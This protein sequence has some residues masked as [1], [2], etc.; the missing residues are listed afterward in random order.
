M[1]DQIQI[2]RDLTKWPLL[3]VVGEP[4]SEE[5]ANE[6]LVRTNNWSLST[7]D[8]SF[9]QQVYDLIGVS[10][11]GRY[12]WPEAESLHQFEESVQA[13]DLHYLSNHQVVSAWIGGPHGWCDWSGRIGS[14]N[15]NIGK[16]PDADDVLED[17]RAIA[18][19][20]P[21]LKLRAQLIPDEGEALHAAVEFEVCDGEVT[22]IA[23]PKVRLAETPKMDEAS[24]LRTLFT[25]NG[26]RG[27]G[28]ERLATAIEQVR[29]S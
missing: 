16:W 24:I 17:W 28:L 2:D 21:Y 22:W 1:T 15:Y 23:S 3:L 11:D 27:V 26:E 13:L 19:A 12:R 25:R 4:V 18:A 5:Q 20:F 6:I 9:E 14:D 29:R 7:N 8:R 10:I